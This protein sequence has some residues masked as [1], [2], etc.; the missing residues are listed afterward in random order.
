MDLHGTYRECYAVFTRKPGKH[1]GLVE[2][3]AAGAYLKEVASKQRVEAL[4]VSANGWL[5]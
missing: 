5:K 2:G 1:I 3:V 4:S